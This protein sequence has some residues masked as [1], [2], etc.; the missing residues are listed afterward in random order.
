M[1]GVTDLIRKIS[2]KIG[3][4]INLMEVCGT[5]T[6]AIFRHGIRSVLPGNIRLLSG[7]GCPVCVTSIEDVDRALHIAG[8]DDVI[9]TTFGDM[10]RVPGS[11]RSLYDARAEGADIR[12]V[13]SPADSL[14]I[15]RENPG[16][17]VVFFATGFET[18]SPSVA[19]TLYM[20]E[21]EGVDNFFIHS[22]HKL[23]PPALRALVEMEDTRIDGFI[24]PGH[25]STIIGTGPYLFLADEHRIASVIAGFGAEDILH[26]ILMLLDQMKTGEYRVAVQYSEVVRPEGNERAMEMVQRY[27]RPADAYWRGMGVIPDSGLVLRDEYS[28]RDMTGTVGAEAGGAEDPPGCRCGDVLTGRIIPA[29][30]PLFGRACTPERPVGACMVSTEGSCAAYYRYGEER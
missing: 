5:H 27:F 23:V 11:S 1:T 16:R 18:T 12:I 19:A 10:M 28:H 15:A 7:P 29:E 20:A 21:T 4:T 3:R 14:R 2:G 24:L 17:R 26:A 8:Q 6:V 30:C 22:V 13:Y 25:V 9:L